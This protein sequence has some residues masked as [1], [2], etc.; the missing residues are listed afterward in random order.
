MKRD[1]EEKNGGRKEGDE[2]ERKG[3]VLRDN[4]YKFKEEGEE[5]G[6]KETKKKDKRKEG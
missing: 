1:K 6:R 3:R 2:E 4:G 5:E